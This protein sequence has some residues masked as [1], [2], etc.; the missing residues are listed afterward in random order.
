MLL[1]LLELIRLDQP[2]PLA[3]GAESGADV[4]DPEAPL[5]KLV[6]GLPRWLPAELKAANVARALSIMVLH[7][8]LTMHRRH[9]MRHVSTTDNAREAEVQAAHEAGLA[10]LAATHD[11]HAETVETHAA[12]NLHLR[13]SLHIAGREA[14]KAKRALALLEADDEKVSVLLFTVTLYANLA[15]SLTRSP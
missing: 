6:R 10:K 11:A 8:E 12:K 2:L 9:L 1:L 4:D 14:E 7:K 3:R 13:R 15:H 5:A